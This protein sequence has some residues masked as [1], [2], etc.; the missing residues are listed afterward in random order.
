MSKQRQISQNVLSIN[1]EN[2]RDSGVAN[3][4]PLIATIVKTARAG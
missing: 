2:M 4:Q 3:K 1:Y